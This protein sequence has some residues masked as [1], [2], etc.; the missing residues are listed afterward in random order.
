M[1]SY[2][3]K[4]YELH[5]A[6]SKVA[7]LKEQG[8]KV[9]FTN[10]CFDLLH[11]G[12]I[13]YLEESRKLGDYLVVGLNSDESV[14][15]LKGNGRPVKTLESRK[16]VLAGLASVDMVIVFEEETP[17]HLI[18]SI[19]PDI[20]VKGGDYRKE[21]IVGGSFVMDKGGRVEVIDFLEGYSSSSI[22]DKMENNG[23][24]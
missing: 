14:K 5:D 16:A 8:S 4:I 9:V 15:R 21:D 13:H 20:L 11:H 22:I 24:D 2:K 10:G 19:V 17:L 18:Q 3:D 6:A 7:E 1:V 12:H 23:N